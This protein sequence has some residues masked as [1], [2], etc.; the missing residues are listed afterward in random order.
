[1]GVKWFWDIIGFFRMIIETLIN[2]G[3]TAFKQVRLL[4]HLFAVIVVAIF[5]HGR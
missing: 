2:V 4:C 1:M 5:E 3:L